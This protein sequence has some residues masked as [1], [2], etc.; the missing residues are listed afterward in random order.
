MKLTWFRVYNYRNI[1]DSGKIDIMNITAFIGQNEA[2]K[3]NLF[4]ALYRV[5]PFDDQ[6]GYNFQEDWPVHLWG[7]KKGKENSKV[8]E[9]VFEIKDKKDIKSL[10]E[11]AISECGDTNKRI[12][13]TPP[14][15]I[16]LTCTSYYNNNRSYKLHKDYDLLTPTVIEKWAKIYLPKFVY[17]HDYELTGSQIELDILKKKKDTVSWDDLSNEEQTILII[18]DLADIDLTELYQKGETAEGRTIRAFDTIQASSYLS[19]QFQEL[20][21]Q[22][23][24]DFDIKIDGT[25]LNIFARDE[26]VGMPVRLY[27][28]STG[29]R[30][31]VSFAWKFTHASK[32]EFKNC[33]LLLEEPGIHLHYSAQQDLLDVFER[34]KSDNTILY[35]T[36][37]ASMV[38]TGF[39]ERIR[40]VEESEN[41][42]AKVKSGVVSS[43]KAPMA[44]IEMR[45]G[46]TGNMSGLLGDRRT[47]IV[48]GGDDAVIL[49]KLSN[50]LKSHGEESI[51]DS[52]YLWPAMGA[53]KTPM[54]AAFAIGQKWQ[55]GVLLDSDSAG[56]DAKEKI[57]KL[58]LDKFTEEEYNFRILLIGK[59]AGIIK[60]DA[61]IE[62]IF[63][64]EFYLELVNEAYRV[65]IKIEDLPVDGSDMITKK[66]EK[67][68]KKN[69]GIQD[70]DK[71]RVMHV[72]LKKF[73]NWEKL[74]DLPQGTLEHCKKLFTSINSSFKIS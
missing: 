41:H 33:I 14:K 6:T 70:L 47:L 51:S 22:K 72:M 23:K 21:R 30:W 74:E 18:L 24:V 63:P 29:F 20:W 9:A 66:V 17:I 65:M 57:K 13:P 45:L 62:D 42:F 39:P 52:I 31:Y 2:G 50:I 43:Q 71:S 56:N 60:T 58:Y 35:T 34:L 53:P 69:F 3:S 67:V 4:E 55:S 25:T 54:Y 12:P 7:E 36:H 10:Y 15:S 46:L 11:F 61:A 28:R 40:I 49:S 44:V 38:D 1:L 27:R 73:D 68:L 26:K 59:A 16:E 37:L 64:D 19:K 8:C 5:N 32:G 48:E